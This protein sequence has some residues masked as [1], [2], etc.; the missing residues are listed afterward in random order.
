[1]MTAA[2]LD[3]GTAYAD[4][5]GRTDPDFVDLYSGLVDQKTLVPGLYNWQSD[6]RF[7]NTLTFNGTA[8]SVWIL[9]VTGKVIVGSGADVTLTGGAKASNIF[10]QVEGMVYIGSDCHVEGI[11][12]SATD[13]E[14]D[15]E[16][17][18]EFRFHPC[19]PREKD[20]PD[21]LY[22]RFFE[23]I[24]AKSDFNCHSEYRV[25]GR[26]PGS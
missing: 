7:P 16:Q 23:F 18:G 17:K 9:Q 2:I 3:M 5:A 24:A 13:E 12:L 14:P 6:V 21:T 25:T 8:D 19:S 20:G 11:F 10:W 4:A 1:M 26:F 22:L 15:G